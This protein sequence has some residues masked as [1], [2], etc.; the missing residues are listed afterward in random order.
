MKTKR[1][2]QIAAI[3]SLASVLLLS[4]ACKGNDKERSKKSKKDSVETEIQLAEYPSLAPQ[5]LDCPECAFHER[6][7]YM[8]R[9]NRNGQILVN[10]QFSNINEIKG[11]VKEFL[12]NPQNLPNLPE[13]EIMSFAHLGNFDVSKGMVFI[14]KDDTD[15]ASRTCMRIVYEINNAICEMYD[16]LSMAK[17]GKSYPELDEELRKEIE[18][19]IPNPMYLYNEVIESEPLPEEPEPVE[20]TIVDDNEEIMSELMF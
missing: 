1:F 19:A 10:G 14:Q 6:D 17:F 20:L 11:Q 16:E 8:I 4:S 2:F 3:V 15:V 9:I 7:I 5:E 12:Q 13:K 18:Q